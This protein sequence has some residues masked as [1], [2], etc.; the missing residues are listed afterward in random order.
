MP[1]TLIESR[2]WILCFQI[3][4]L[5]T[6]KLW[7]F[8]GY[9]ELLCGL[10]L[11]H[12]IRNQ[13]FKLCKFCSLIQKIQAAFNF[14]CWVKVRSPSLIKNSSLINCEAK[15]FINECV[16]HSNICV[17]LASKL[18]QKIMCESVSISMSIFYAWANS[19]MNEKSCV[20]AETIKLSCYSICVSLCL[21]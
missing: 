20:R 10:G 8:R 18:I 21:R 3:D 6:F 16:L 12:W 15:F 17:S 1:A 9:L 5:C 13:N 11:S 19:V 2:K 4:W 14:N 7:K